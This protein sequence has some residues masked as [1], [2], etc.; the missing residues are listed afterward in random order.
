MSFKF[1]Y[2]SDKCNKV[3]L[4]VSAPEETVAQPGDLFA[5]PD[6]SEVY[7]LG[8]FMNHK[9]DCD[10]VAICLSNGNRFRDPT[11]TI[12]LATENLRW[13]G[14]MDITIKPKG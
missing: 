9:G 13:L 8:A 5:H 11:P 4:R 3:T 14:R 1:A 2:H 10:Y 7:I 12:E 6:D